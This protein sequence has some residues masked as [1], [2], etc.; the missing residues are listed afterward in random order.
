MGAT[1][2]SPLGFVDLR[3]LLTR[4]GV[5]LRQALAHPGIVPDNEA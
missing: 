2:S 4:L 5:H 1:A 3:L